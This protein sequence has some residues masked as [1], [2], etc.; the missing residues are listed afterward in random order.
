MERSRETS[1]KLAKKQIAAHRCVNDPVTKHLEVARAMARMGNFPGMA[2]VAAA[3]V[4]RHEV[5]V[6]FARIMLSRGATPRQI[7]LE[8]ERGYRGVKCDPLPSS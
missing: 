8:I 7:V 1:R 3:G 5:D 6:A 4:M 2:D